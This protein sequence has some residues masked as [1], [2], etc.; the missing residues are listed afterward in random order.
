MFSLML[1]FNFL[2]RRICRQINSHLVAMSA[3]TEEEITLELGDIVTLSS[4]VFGTLTGKIIYRDAEVIRI[5][6]IDAS[7]RGQN[8]PMD[9]DGDFAE[10]TGIT[11]VVLHAK[12]TD[13]H[14][15]TI[16]G[17]SEGE[18]LEFFTIAGEQIDKERP[19]IVAKIEDDDEN[20]AI[21]LSDGRRLD[22][23][24][25]GPPSPI[26][27]IRVRAADVEEA[28]EGAQEAAAETDMLPDG[29]DLSL[30]EGML[31]A[32]MVE[33][34]PTAERSYP[35]VIQREDM[36]I[37][38][39]KEYSE[40]QQ[41]NPAILR[42]LA[43]ETEL[44]LALKHAAT[45][46]GEDGVQ[47]PFIKSADTLQ[48][49]LTRLGTPV[50]SIIP[51]L[52][53]K[54]I[55]YV[56]SGAAVEPTEE[57]L[58]QLEFRNWI[59]HELRN[60]RTSTA[61]L[62]GQDV[63]GAQ[64]NKLMY[65]YLYDVLFREGNVLVPGVAGRASEEIM[66][67][68]DVLRSAA[69]PTLALGYSKLGKDVT[70]V[71]DRNVTQ[72]KTRQIRALSSLKTR[73]QDIIAPGDSATALNYIVLPANVGSTWRPTKFSGSLA[74][75]IRASNITKSLPPLE[76]LTN[77]EKSYGD[78]KFQI[79][80]GVA[81][82]EG[83]DPSAISV[84]DWLKRNLEQN[85]HPEDL[86][87][88]GSV[89]VNR[90]LDSIGLRSYEWSPTVAETLW[91]AI[92]KAQTNYQ[93]AYG[94][95]KQEIEKEELTPY[96]VGAAIPADS[97]LWTQ[98][99]EVPELGAALQKL[100]EITPAQGDWDLAQAQHLL[101]SAESTLIMIL[102][103]K[104]VGSPELKK[105]KEVYLG[106]VKRALLVVAA[107]NANLAKY[108]ASPIINTCPHV[109]DKD[110]LRQVMMRDE[111][112]FHAVL[113]RFLQRYQGERKDNWI[114]CAVCSTHLIC[115]HEVMMLY[116][117]THPGR[118]PALHKEIL[119]DFGG[120]AFNGKYI[121]RNCGVAISE[122]E[123]DTHIEFD[124]EGR[125]L[126]G[127]A[128]LDEG[129][130]TADDELDAILNISLAKKTVAFEDEVQQEL[131]DIARVLAQTAGFSFD[132]TVYREIVQFTYKYL[133]TTLPPKATFEAM[134][135]KR[136]VRPT[137]EA[138]KATSEVAVTTA[139]LLCQIHT[140]QPFPEVLFPF[141]GCNFK[142]G[143]FPIETDNNGDIGALEYF[144]CLIANIN[145]N[146]EPWNMTMWSTESSVDKRQNTV[147]EWVGRMFNES[148]IK[149]LLQ[150]TRAFYTD[151]VKERIGGAS[152]G[153][154]LPFTFRPA[155]RPAKPAMDEQ[156]TV[157]DRILLSAAD[158]P[159]AE[160]LPVVQKRA[161]E[162]ALNSILN[163]HGL[164]KDK[165]LISETSTRSEA[166]CCYQSIQAVKE[167][168]SA[169][170]N[171]EAVAL[172]V[173]GLRIAETLLRK[174]D[175]VQQANG[176]HLW[177]RWSPPVAI[178]SIGVA[179]DAAY[180]KMFMRNC[181]RGSREGEAHE[182]GHRSR[183]YEC[184]HC[185]FRVTRDPLI[186]MSDLNDEEIY[187]NDSKRK[188]PPRTVVREEAAGALKE[189]GIE[190]NSATFDNLL[191]S[192]RKNRLVDPFI[193]PL[194][195]GSDEIFQSLSELVKMDSPFMPA[196]LTE[197]TLVETAMAANFAR[198]A[199]PS[200]EA[201]KIT[202]AAFVSKYDSL[203]N[204]ILD[205][206]E[207]RQG[208][209]Q[210]KQVSRKVE[211]IV[212]AIERL[213]E[214][215]FYQGPNEINK[216]WVI[217]LQRLASRYSE[218]VFGAGAWFG[219]GER[220][221]L[222]N[223][224]KWFGKQVSQRHSAKFEEMIQRILGATQDSQKELNKPETRDS[225]S[226][227]TNQ[228]ATYMG[229]LMHFWTNSMVSFKVWGVSEEEIRYMLR[230]L[231]LS[232]IESLLLIES[233]LYLTIPKDA[234]KSQIQRIL[235]AWTKATFTEGRKQFDLFGM[236]EE[237]V[238]LAILDAREKEK[239]TVIKEIDDEKDP[240]L[241]AA[242][243]VQKNL[244]IGRW[245]IGTSKNLSSYNAEFWDFL[246][247]QRDKIG[248]VDNTNGRPAPVAE[249]AVGYDFGQEPEADRGFDTYAK[250]DEDEGGD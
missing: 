196:R 97:T 92:A 83:M 220:N 18:R 181:F 122:F 239:I 88:S 70:S 45:V 35:E 241:R 109:K 32:A 190:V 177:V 219:S 78:T 58:G 194:D 17:V 63:G 226:K 142:R 29:Y 162:L 24:F 237:E 240:D 119:L 164:A 144:V 206:L 51:V 71:D 204:G 138:F 57:M 173:D 38:L 242:A 10:A 195:M 75:D 244:K 26:D 69:P 61:Y 245:A 211:E 94:F 62:S 113:S 238:R 193:E 228:L 124:D 100:K 23:A 139:V 112:K 74:E 207:G 42:R 103:K 225:S 192:I 175:P 6:P 159:L 60:Y 234:T 129:E 39:L 185:K 59:E 215:P 56:D 84:K 81:N 86:Q 104:L 205:I 247:D 128:E 213:T 140:I 187:N 106:E 250:Q 224:T 248:R 123:Y 174:R 208:R 90:V 96:V 66:A 143:G 125:P 202:W 132:E 64:I 89:G 135:A 30:L 155:P 85:V 131:Y 145:R 147:R 118:A 48:S 95:F 115:I 203:R 50:S 117:R 65:S 231:V 20:D 31:P 201:R 246:Q 82:A 163:A 46:T 209:G 160:I 179:P 102:Y 9:E 167:G 108:K 149:I 221:K 22:F 229:R 5:Q 1:V 67:D 223:G 79:V 188:G 156:P 235:L 184:R 126:V 182:F 72:I 216:H 41:K 99:M 120:A 73:T 107:V 154:L 243:L 116:E 197:W 178:P 148:E 11:N 36:Y 168:G 54:R 13:P 87:S 198:K 171:P 141:A 33:E 180:F 44:L 114:E 183:F 161:Y 101:S 214:E 170:F 151:T 218:M 150:K 76:V 93:H 110:V 12:R 52:A 146:T 169:I 21:T 27:I 133:T 233:P 136:K 15:C 3:P 47:R 4:T 199:A 236:T 111:S 68:Q 249:D 172:E 49:I 34:I 153:D 25:I 176:A 14:F 137:Y 152:A 189:N 210:V 91:K 16:L 166:M 212:L 130:K 7:D 77:E 2:I 121:C 37:D 8:V 217:G 80:K 134:T 186:L 127:R 158:A 98:A 53:A 232:S 19:A 165:S 40:T 105:A 227:V 55:L 157:P 222:F 191:S 200:E 230:W 43:R 28:A